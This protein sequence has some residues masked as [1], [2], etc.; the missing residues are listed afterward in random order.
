M[1]QVRENYAII[2][3]DIAKSNMLQ[4]IAHQITGQNDLVVQKRSDNLHLKILQSE[5]ALS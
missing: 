4:N 5:Y 1:N 2:L 3:A